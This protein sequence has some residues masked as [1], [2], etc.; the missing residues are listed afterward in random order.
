VQGRGG[1]SGGLTD[2]VPPE[3]GDYFLLDHDQRNTLHIG[4]KITLPWNSY[5][6]T[7]IYYGSGFTD[8]DAVPGGPD[9]LTGHTTFDVTISKSFKER[10]T[11][12][13]SGT[14]LANRRFLLDNSVTFGGTHYFNPREMFVQVRYRF[15]Y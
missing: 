11:V 1:I 9:H 5:A 6:S 7:D 4:G 10:L 12:S 2:F 15:H 3:N 14:N 8:G 13:A